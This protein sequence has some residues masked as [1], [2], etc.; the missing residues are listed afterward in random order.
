MKRLLL[1]AL[2][3]GGPA[4][5][6]KLK[7]PDVVDDA[8]ELVETDRGQA[9]AALE[10][11]L[12]NED[13]SPE[14]R[15]AITVHAGEQRRLKGD[16]AAARKHFQAVA[17]ARSETPW[18]A[19][20]RLGIA[21]LDADNQLDAKVVARLSE[22]GDKEVLPTENAD[23]Y[24]FLAREAAVRKDAAD[25]RD[26]VK[27]AE[28]FA[29]DDPDVLARITG[30]KR[31]LDPNAPVTPD[32]PRSPIE[33]AEAAF[34]ADRID[35]ARRMATEIAAAGGPD[36]YVAK[37]LLMRLDAKPVDPMKIGVLLPL[38]GKYAAAGG[39]IR[40]ALAAGY[41]NGAR[42]LVFVDSGE[43]DESSVQALEKL[44]LQDG[45]V[46]VVGP[47]RTESLDAVAK[48]ADALRVPLISLAQS[49]AG[50]P[51]PWV[52]QGMVTPKDQVRAL[53]DYAVGKREMKAFATFAP[54]NPYGH[55]AA[56][57]LRAEIERRQLTLVREVFYDPAAKDLAPFARQ[58]AA[59]DFEGQAELLKKLKAEAKA[60]GK[61]PSKVTLPPN[62]TYDAIFLPDNATRIP[63][64]CAG[65]GFEEFAIGAFTPKGPGQ[66][67]I[68]L[69]GLSGWDND[70]MVQ[71]GGNYVKGALFTD[72][73]YAPDSEAFATEYRAK[74]DRTPSALEAV[75][76]DLG[77]LLAAAGADAKTRSAFRD[78]M[79]SA[80]LPDAATGATGFVE[81]RAKHRIRILTIGKNGIYAADTAE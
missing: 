48:A 79:M 72:L 16:I 49:D 32:K 58:L 17:D 62:V 36:A 78:A 10:K 55:S 59:K 5:A 50:D 2:L 68:P 66:R 20:A 63:L 64:A 22:P 42:K 23:R 29:K 6:A 45:V 33:K 80:S 46:A 24:A 69:L 40:E 18:R 1:L 41:G 25:V 4:I 65:L 11:A 60:K 15:D 35:D 61:D 12:E 9:I 7:T 39:Q 8:L 3:L 38:S 54:D 51:Y 14:D 74:L 75:S 73:W 53:V 56:D 26:F 81:R 52:L 34:E 77:R 44:V 71:R 31:N 27:R 70:D 43:T 13:L 21:L 19:S 47:L 57:A 30:I 37:Y 76:W 67:T 28:S